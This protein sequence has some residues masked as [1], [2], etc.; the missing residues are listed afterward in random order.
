[1]NASYSIFNHVNANKQSR[2][3]KTIDLHG[4]HV[5]EALQILS[6]IIQSEKQEL[7]RDE[8]NVRTLNVITGVGRNSAKGKAKVKPAVEAFLKR[9]GYR[10][11]TLSPGDLQIT[12]K[13]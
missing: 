2:D 13:K 12:I 7:E 5:S 11:K 3:T 8:R 4:L 9:E 6:Q 1:M 10:I